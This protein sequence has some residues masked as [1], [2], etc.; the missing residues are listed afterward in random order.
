MF[1]I[2]LPDIPNT[3]TALVQGGQTQELLHERPALH[4]CPLTS[5]L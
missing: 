1:T 2:V 4:P 5:P 3:V